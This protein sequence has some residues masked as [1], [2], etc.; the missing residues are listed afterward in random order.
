MDDADSTVA[1]AEAVGDEVTTPDAGSEEDE[2]NGSDE[3][4]VKM[5][6][7]ALAEPYPVGVALFA[8]RGSPNAVLPA[9]VSVEAE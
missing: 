9:A 1:S 5:G 8:L 2:G 3:D 6:E 4:D 7:A